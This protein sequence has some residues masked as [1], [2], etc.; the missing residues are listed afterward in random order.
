MRV[1]S[2]EMSMRVTVP[3]PF[4]T[5]QDSLT[6]W[7]GVPELKPI[8]D[9]QAVIEIHRIFSG[10]EDAVLR[11]LRLPPFDKGGSE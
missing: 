2:E 7:D 6:M 8:T 10:C 3:Y 11:S 9:A 4:R 5:R 1:D